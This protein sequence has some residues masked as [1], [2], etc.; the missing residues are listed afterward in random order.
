MLAIDN[1][2]RFVVPVLSGH[3]DGANALAARVAD[4]LGATAVITTASDVRGTIAVNILGRELGWRVEAPKI[5]LTRVAARV[6][7]GEPIAFV[8]EAG[9]KD[10]W[11]GPG[12]LP[13]N[14]WLLDRIEDLDPD[15]DSRG[16]VLLMARREIPAD[17]WRRFKGR[18][19]VYRPPED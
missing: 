13:E 3:I 12:P 8:Q 4:L 16:A 18:L 14:T 6:V 1:A 15:L 17:L 19:V 10:W 2:G 7:D 5:N 9:S 11:T